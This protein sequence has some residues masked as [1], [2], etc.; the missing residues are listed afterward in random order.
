MKAKDTNFFQQHVEKIGLVVAVL[1]FLGVGAYY[2]GGDP[3]AAEF[4][5]ERITPGEIESRLADAVQSVER[6]IA[7]DG[8]LPERTEQPAY[9]ADFKQRFNAIAEWRSPGDREG[10]RRTLAFA[11][12]LELPGLAPAVLRGGDYNQP[13]YYVPRPPVPK[14]PVVRTGYGVLGSMDDSDHRRELIQTI[15]QQRAQD[16][17][18]ASV[19]ARF[20]MDDYVQR[21]QEGPSD[22]NLETLREQWWE[23]RRGL[24]GVYLQRQELDPLTGE[25]GNT[26]IIEPLPGQMGYLPRQ[27][28]WEISEIQPAIDELLSNQEHVA[29]PEFLPLVKGIWQAPDPDRQLSAGDHR[30][31]HKLIQD[32][33]Q[34]EQRRQTLLDQ[35]DLIEKREARLR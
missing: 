8:G 15:G 12:P 21:F 11:V 31:I 1:F 35:I 10:A 3:H 25:W 18:W 34:D 2:L 29:R 20:P 9:A 5:G 30:E 32:I 22:P 19:A 33:L 24:A 6:A 13:D 28:D 4:Q 14:R 16:L 26:T 17:R 27:G 7:T 23:Q